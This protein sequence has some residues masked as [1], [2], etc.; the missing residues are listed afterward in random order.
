MLIE[1]AD[2]EQMYL[3]IKA[4]ALEDGG[5]ITVLI[6][7]APDCD[8]LC[9]CRILSS[10]LKSD[11][12]QYKIKPVAGYSDIE[13]A[14]KE[15][16]D[17]SEEL[18]S[19]VL[20]NCGGRINLN[21]TFGLTINNESQSQSG[22]L[23]TDRYCFFFVGGASA[24]VDC[25]AK[26]S[27]ANDIVVHF[28]GTGAGQVRCFVLDSHRPIHLANIHAGSE[29][30]VVNDGSLRMQDLPS[31]GSDLSDVDS[32]EDSGDDFDD[33]DDDDDILDDDDSEGDDVLDSDSESQGMLL[34]TH[35]HPHSEFE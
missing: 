18:R 22:T 3:E 34:L 26:V 7:V 21:Q 11:R 1:M 2:L 29:I 4:S 15:Y 10:L 12:I 31:D 5:G 33:D 8:A 27:K 16:I 24:G 30:V 19:I 28:T 25:I 9:T 20:L 13:F 17:D 32:S 23:Q 14:K 6:L 35:M